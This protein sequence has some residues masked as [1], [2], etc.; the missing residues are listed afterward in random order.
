MPEESVTELLHRVTS[1]SKSAEKL[2]MDRVY[3]DLHAMAQGYFRYENPGH[4]LQPTALVNE[5][6][7]KLVADGKGDWK[8]R[9]HFFAVASRVMRQILTDHARREKAEK[10]GGG[11]PHIP[12]DVAHACVEAKFADLVIFDQA[13]GAL[14]EVHPRLAEVVVCRYFGDMTE[15][16][17]AEFQGVS[18]RTV[19]R[20]WEFAR[21][22]LREWLTK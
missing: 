15:D 21:A 2:L 17:I 20:D 10:R 8:N 7:V 16:E 19:R 12:V 3:P 18:T 13:L 4:T 14:E 22:W 9:A 5:V 6:Y 11:A 1:G